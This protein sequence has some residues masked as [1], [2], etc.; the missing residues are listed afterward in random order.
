MK[1]PSEHEKEATAAADENYDYDG[2][3]REELTEALREEARDAALF[4]GFLTEVYEH[5][6]DGRITNPRTYPSEVI[7]VVDQ[8]AASEAGARS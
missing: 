2:M 3:S 1:L 8:I 5:V 6:T 4:A 7:G